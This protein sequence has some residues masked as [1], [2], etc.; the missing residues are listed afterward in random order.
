MYV[1]MYVCIYIYRLFVYS[2]EYLII[3]LHLPHN[4]LTSFQVSN[5]V[6]EICRAPRDAQ[7]PQTCQALYMTSVVNVIM[8]PY[9]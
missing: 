1:C 2:H 7:D 3:T 4:M 9:S 6:A 8:V 5:D